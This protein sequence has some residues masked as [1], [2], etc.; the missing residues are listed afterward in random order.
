MSFTSQTS[1]DGLEDLKPSPKLDVITKY[2]N[3]LDFLKNAKMIIE[4]ELTEKNIADEEI[5]KRLAK[6]S[7]SISKLENMIAEWE[8]Q[9]GT[10]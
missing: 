6:L 4:R 3:D 5:D 7:K 10:D 2:R 9:H 8:A 1:E